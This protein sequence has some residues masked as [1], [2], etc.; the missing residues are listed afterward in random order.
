D[1]TVFNY[2]YILED[3]FLEKGIIETYNVGPGDEVFMIGRYVDHDQKQCNQPSARFGNISVMDP[4]PLPHRGLPKGTQE[5]VLAEV[6][7]IVGYSGSP[8]FAFVPPLSI[9]HHKDKTN[10][11]SPLQYGPWL[12]GINWSY[13]GRPE[14]LRDATK[15]EPNNQINS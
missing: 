4:D 11:Q 13:L 6:R 2:R 3:A 5:S 12:L 10:D 9:R 1:M 8:V 7:S 14:L 15:P